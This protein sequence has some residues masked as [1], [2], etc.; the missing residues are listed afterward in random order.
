MEVTLKSKNVE[1]ARP[2]RDYIEKKVL[3]L[4][5]FFQG[6]SINAQVVVSAEKGLQIAEV[7]VQ[8]NG[9]L[10]RGEEKTGDMYASI[11]GAV[12][13]IERQI[14]KYKT[15]SIGGCVRPVQA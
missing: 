1:L 15:E 11:D 14:R 10:L 8:V 7:T 13:K 3:K 6:D 2:I 5:K 9:L 4:Q 12:D